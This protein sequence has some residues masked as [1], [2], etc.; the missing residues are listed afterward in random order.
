MPQPQRRGAAR[1]P[2]RRTA[3]RSPHTRG[4]STQTSKKGMD[5]PGDE[6][7]STTGTARPERPLRSSGSSTPRGTFVKLAN[8]TRNQSAQRVTSGSGSFL[9][10]SLPGVI[11]HDR[12]DT[13]ALERDQPID[14]SRA[15]SAR[16]G[17]GIERRGADLERS[18]TAG[19]SA[20]T[21]RPCRRTRNQARSNRSRFMTLSHAATKSRTNAASESSHA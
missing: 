17:Y 9:A 6:G 14:A 4:W 12:R 11:P 15:R 21:P 19:R 13:A 5:V 7:S 8:E 10:S 2:A 20:R 3:P 1:S 16:T 18:V